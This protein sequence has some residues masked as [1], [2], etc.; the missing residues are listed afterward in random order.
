MDSPVRHAP[1]SLHTTRPKEADTPPTLARQSLTSNPSTLPSTFSIM[2]L[3][4]NDLLV[5]AGV[6]G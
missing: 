2:K 5:S 4:F 1:D 3:T 6:L